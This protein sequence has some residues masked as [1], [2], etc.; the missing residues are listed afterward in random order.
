MS[1]VC[2]PFIN[3]NFYTSCL[4]RIQW[5]CV[6]LKENG[7]IPISRIKT[8]HQDIAQWLCIPVSTRTQCWKCQCCSPSHLLAL[9]DLCIWWP[10]SVCSA[11]KMSPLAITAWLSTQAHTAEPSAGEKLRANVS[12]PVCC[13]SELDTPWPRLRSRCRAFSTL[14]RLC[15]SR[16][17][18][19]EQR[20]A[21]GVWSTAKV[22]KI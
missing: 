20:C 14:D 16:L 22:D 8:I 2:P 11:E 19:R 13:L 15:C 5:F 12:F 9:T 7:C 1:D 6:K 10:Y 18:Y 3:I 17:A 4:R 21:N